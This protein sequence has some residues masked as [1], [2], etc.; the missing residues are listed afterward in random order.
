MIERTIFTDLIGY[1]PESRILELLIN[2]RNEEY[3]F[4]KI[5]IALGINRQ[6]CYQILN[7]YRDIDLIIKTK[8]IRQCQYYRINKKDTR[9]KLLINLFRA[10]LKGK[11]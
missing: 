8:K 3:T 5:A 2:G 10:S 4:N 7:Y 9:A 6:A 11:D 1:T